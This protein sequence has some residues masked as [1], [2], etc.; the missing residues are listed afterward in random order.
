M[1]PDPAKKNTK[2]FRMPMIIPIS[3]DTS[4]PDP[5]RKRELNLRER[6]S[7]RGD[8]NRDGLKFPFFNV[9]E[10]ERVWI[11]EM[12]EEWEHLENRQE[13]DLYE[14]S[15]GQILGKPFLDA[16]SKYT[17]KPPAAITGLRL[18]GFH[19]EIVPEIE[20]LLNQIPTTL[21][22]LE[23]ISYED[24][25]ATAVPEWILQCPKLKTLT[26]IMPNLTHLPPNLFRSLPQL[27]TLKLYS[28]KLIEIPD[29]FDDS[30]K[31][32]FLVLESAP[33]LK[34]LPKSLYRCPTLEKIRF[35]PP[36]NIVFS[37]DD[38]RVLY[39]RTMSEHPI[40]LAYCSM[41]IIPVWYTR[42]FKNIFDPVTFTPE[43][44]P[45]DAVPMTL[46]EMFAKVRPHVRLN[47]TVVERIEAALRNPLEPM[48]T[49]D[50]VHSESYQIK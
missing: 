33:L 39:A 37:P 44:P 27:F 6:L 3:Q 41:L 38:Q 9:K 18:V 15:M 40:D 47:W 1:S 11:L 24:L 13:G 14:I 34:S 25:H 48:P 30:S 31:F 2:Y 46:Q 4:S 49:W 10:S 42:F 7:Y 43:P 23:N 32:R 8:P 12:I 16:G 20:A 28:P 22:M 50:E 19:K 36:S 35:P 29:F 21:P 26:L 17:K 5:N 45:C